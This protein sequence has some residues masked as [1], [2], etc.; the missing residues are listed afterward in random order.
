VPPVPLADHLAQPGP[1]R[2]TRGGIEDV[3]DRDRAAE[4]HGGFW[5]TGL[6]QRD[7]LSGDVASLI[8]LRVT[9][10]PIQTRATRPLEQ[11]EELEMT[12]VARRDVLRAGAGGAAMLAVGLPQAPTGV[13]RRSDHGAGTI[14]E[15]NRTLLGIL[16]TPGSHPATVHP[17][18]GF[19]VLHAAVHDAVT[20]ATG[21]H[22]P[23]Q[24]DVKATGHPSPVAA[25]AQAAHD[26]LVAL[27]PAEA[28]VLD[29][30][31]AADL[32]A[33]PDGRARTDGVRIGA[34][35]AAS[36]LTARADD[37]SAATPPPLAPGTDP[38][39]YRTTPPAFAP[40]VF[41]HWPA[42]RPFLL[43]RPDE[44]RPAA[45]PTLA[46][47]AYADALKE[48]VFR[49]QDVSASRILDQTIQARFWSAPIWNYWNEIAQSVVT[50]RSSDIA[51]AAHL[52]AA[53]NLAFAD[54]VIA[55]YDAK[56]HHRIWRPITAVRC[57]D[58]DGNRRT[59]G[60]PAWNP[61]AATPAD[62]SYP[63]A[64]SVISEAG[65][66]VLIRFYGP[67][68]PV[69]VTSEVLPA[70]KRVFHRFQDAAE[71]AGRSRIYAGVHTRLDHDAG[72]RLGRDVA[73][74]VVAR[75]GSRIT[76]SVA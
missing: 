25:T 42:V 50:A 73:R 75:A 36:V 62:P 44:F 68:R 43:D 18:R 1:S 26:T 5:R 11:A 16:R 45:Y 22:R 3:A 33:V 47:D 69:T 2:A 64:H 23:Y 55:F 61:L 35:T 13:R 39:E 71:A 27:Y 70:V 24:F 65:A 14:I 6:G 15:W 21:H 40:A 60:D 12:Q 58:S 57:A 52:F 38:G 63:G 34:L 17:T 72:K 30:Q 28:D 74:F 4:H 56:Y 9:R 49:G 32:A 8:V 31:L 54:A 29:R 66:T 59:T 53:L 20:A 76:R 51:I 19:A 67:A 7:H 48:V 37:G 46:S 10:R 41:T